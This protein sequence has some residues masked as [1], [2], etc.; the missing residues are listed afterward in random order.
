MQNN[1]N[2]VSMVFVNDSQCLLDAF[3]IFASTFNKGVDTY[4]NPQHFLDN[5]NQYPKHI[6]ILLGQ[7]YNNF[8]QKGIQIAE[9]LHDLG[10][11][12][13]YLYSLQNFSGRQIPNYLTVILKPDIL[14]LKHILKKL[15]N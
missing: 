7:R 12:N 8:D 1:L 11:T 2:K 13:L 15:C 14:S 5:I 3:T 4:Q 10:F 6:K 9:G